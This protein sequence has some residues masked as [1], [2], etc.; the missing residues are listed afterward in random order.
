MTMAAMNMVSAEG[1]SG[2]SFHSRRCPQGVASVLCKKIPIFGYQR[3]VRPSDG[4]LLSHQ[5]MRMLLLHSK[6]KFTAE[7]KRSENLNFRKMA[8][9]VYIVQAFRSIFRSKAD[10][11]ITRCLANGNTIIDGV[12]NHYTAWLGS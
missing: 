3:L 1:F 2:V 7:N 11:P 10:K 9:F 4:I 8:L 6:V 12:H 5:S